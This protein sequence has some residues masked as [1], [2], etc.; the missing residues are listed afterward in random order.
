MGA[1]GSTTAKVDIIPQL[2]HFTQYGH[3]ELQSF[4][5]RGMR[6]LSETFALRIN[7]FEFLLNSKLVT[8]P[9]CRF[10]FNQVLDTDKNGLVDKMEVMCL[11]CLC[12]SLSNAEKVEYIFEL[13][14]FNEKG[15]LVESELSL[16]LLSITRVVNKVDSKFE[17]PP[18]PIWKHVIELAFK[19]FSFIDQTKKSIRKPELV[20]FAAG[21]P[22]VTYYLDAFRGH[23]SQV[24]MKM[25]K[26]KPSKVNDQPPK[27]AQ[28]ADGKKWCDVNF[29]A[30]ESSITPLKEWEA[31]G[32]LPY[33]FVRW[34]R[35]EHV[36]SATAT[37]AV[38]F[39]FTHQRAVLRS[40]EKKKIYYGP[41][42]VGNGYF[43]Q[44]L[45]ADR[46]LLNGLAMALGNP[47]LIE[48]LFGNTGQE[49]SVGRFNARIFEGC[50]WRGLFV[51]DRIP[52]NPQCQPLF[53]KSSDAN[54]AWPFIY[55]KVVAKYLGSYG[56]IALCSKRMDATMWAVR[57]TTGG[58]VTRECTADYEWKSVDSE[59][60]MPEKNGFL[61]L[62]SLLVEGSLVSVGRSEGMAMSANCFAKSPRTTPPH[63]YLYPVVVAFTDA[64]GFK[65]IKIRDAFRE[66]LDFIGETHNSNKDYQKDARIKVDEMSG[67]CNTILIPIEK[68]PEL[69]DT[70][71]I[72]RFPDALKVHAERM[73]LKPWRTDYLKMRTRGKENPA[74]FFLK[75]VGH[76]RDPAVLPDE[77]KADLRLSRLR[78]QQDKEMLVSDEIVS[79][80]MNTAFDYDR[81]R[82][83]P[84]AEVKRNEKAVT[85]SEEQL[86]LQRKNENLQK[87]LTPVDVC[88][89]VSS[90]CPWGVGGAPEVGAKLRLRI[91]PSMRTIKVIRVIMKKKKEL[92]AEALAKQ[93]EALK[94]QAELLA[95]EKEES[96]APEDKEPPDAAKTETANESDDES[97]SGSDSDDRED[98]TSQSE[99]TEIPE[100]IRLK[101]EED[102]RLDEIRN[103]E[104]ILAEEWFEIRDAAEQCWMSKSVKL[105][106]GEYYILADVTYDVPDEKMFHL[107]SPKDKTECPWLDGRPLEV[108]KIWLQVS[109]VGQ[110]QMKC[111]FDPKECPKHAAS[112]SN[113]VVTPPR[114]PFSAENQEE[115]ASRG[116][117]QVMVDLRSQVQ[118]ASAMLLA[119]GQEFKNKFRHKLKLY[120]KHLDKVEADRKK[121]EEEE[122]MRKRLEEDRLEE[123]RKLAAY[124]EREAKMKKDKEREKKLNKKGLSAKASNR[125]STRTNDTTNTNTETVD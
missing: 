88:L 33:R 28:T 56:N 94:R 104:H 87:L 49:D 6:D 4:W 76:A 67:Q 51:D 73:R 7:E 23:A 43:K 68:L 36:G 18:A 29:P 107:A 117:Q 108:N 31:K 83:F 64:S 1:H 52:C 109:S 5:V 53:T 34:R 112:V 39:L 27:V 118:V 74:K 80:D 79:Q 59:V 10:L 99:S 78:E 22:Q 119:L 70:I 45:L 100:H 98:A 11:I 57:M 58:H 65:F 42:I 44:G 115:T 106:P 90:T 35:R 32:L 55:E 8:L 38:P 61:K 122:M 125:E 69:F 21:V 48:H 3:S 116:L 92:V 97:E 113:V 47:V 66:Y 120:K 13:F 12:S 30:N 81:P 101:N 93:A 103:K 24:F 15:Y 19:H 26:W 40:L 16:S 41:G 82:S 121:Q 60:S 91:V 102:A 84:N 63:G 86:V 14:N 96:V 25:K 50:G 110:F 2:H 62:Q 85:V 9:V 105:Y 54:E 75:V 17:V 124:R 95:A 72:S 20:E 77:H 123:E 71:I 111:M 89:T 37:D 114:W 46:W